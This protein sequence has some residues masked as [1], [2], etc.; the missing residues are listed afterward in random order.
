MPSAPLRHLHAPMLDARKIESDVKLEARYDNGIS[1]WCKR[2]LVVRDRNETETFV[3]QSETE[4]SQE[5]D[6]DPFQDYELR[7]I[8]IIRPTLCFSD[9]MILKQSQW[10][11]D[12]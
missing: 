7:H 11:T 9:V 8:C 4:T 5:R 1:Q 10:V 12:L 3:L 2:D 6:R